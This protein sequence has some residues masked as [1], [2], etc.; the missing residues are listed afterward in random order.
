[1]AA[2]DF[3]TRWSKKKEG[4]IPEAVPASSNAEMA[5]A[6]SLPSR[7]STSTDTPRPLPT[8]DDVEKLTRDSD[9]SVFMTQGVDESV[10]RSAMK[11]LFADPHFNVMDG[12][13]VYI[14]DFTKFE[15][16]T[17][18]VLA[19]LNH[20]KNLLDPLSQ[21]QTPL[22]NLLDTGSKDEEK[23][24]EGMDLKAIP[25]ETE[26]PGE[27]TLPEQGSNDPAINSESDEP[28]EQDRQQAQGERG[29]SR[30]VS[31]F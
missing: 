18:A 8:Q 15:P 4:D 28:A 9:Y 25:Y 21:L 6:S 7:T 10:R 31:D 19:S 26:M 23:D 22:M 17:P 24:D 13:D 20:V 3:F 27:S 2:E 12:L 29:A 16:I 30:N 1:M 14:E 11:K 5:D